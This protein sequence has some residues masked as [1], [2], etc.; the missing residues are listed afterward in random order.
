MLWVVVFLVI[1]LAGLAM[2]VA[3]TVWLAH[4]TADLLAELGVLGD[5]AAQL[6]RLLGEVRSPGATTF[7]GARDRG[8]KDPI[9][10]G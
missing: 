5:Q 7:G 2:L 4:K 6:A 1:A 3:Y 10:V 8:A 9:D